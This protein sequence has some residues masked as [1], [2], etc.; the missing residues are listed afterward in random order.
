MTKTLKKFEDGSADS[1]RW[2]TLT[3]ATGQAFGFALAYAFSNRHLF[4]QENGA[5]EFSEAL[6]DTFT[7]YLPVPL[8]DESIAV[9]HG[10]VEGMAKASIAEDE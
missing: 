7:D 3:N 2:Y 8:S 6:Y 1:E 9:L 5:Q 10:I 4:E